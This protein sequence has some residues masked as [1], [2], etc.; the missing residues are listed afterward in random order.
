MR[1]ASR[2]AARPAPSFP[3]RGSSSRS[4]ETLPAELA[5]SRRAGDST[6]RGVRCAR[7]GRHP[8]GTTNCSRPSSVLGG[9]GAD[10]GRFRPRDARGRAA[11]IRAAMVTAGRSTAWRPIEVPAGHPVDASRPL[12]VGQAAARR[13]HGRS[14]SARF[15]RLRSHRPAAGL[16]EA[17]GLESAHDNFG[18]RFT[19]WRYVMSHA[20]RP[21]GVEMDWSASGSIVTRA[22]VFSMTVTSGLI[23][24][25]LAIGTAGG[26]STTGTSPRGLRPGHIATPPTT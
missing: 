1:E 2:R 20:N 10:A 23:G 6:S 21:E 9:R 14:R 13:Q 24:G 15:I 4:L 3:T 18:Q 16:R 11:W 7:R 26:R 19:N 12:V 25:L 5:A 22:A 17:A 8:P